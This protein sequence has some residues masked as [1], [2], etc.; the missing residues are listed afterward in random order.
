MKRVLLLLSFI[1]LIT[2]G[3]AQVLPKPS[4]ARLVNDAAHLLTPDQIASLESK[5]V[6]YDDSTSNQVVIVT[7]TTLGDMDANQYATELGRAWGVGGKE[8]N[9]GVVILVSA[10]APETGEQRKVYITAGY[11]LEGAL[12]D[13]TLK[14][15]VDNEMIPNLKL[16]NYYRAF[17]EATTAIIQAAAGE[18]KAPEGYNRRGKQSPIP[19]GVIILIIILVIFFIS[20]SG[21]GGGGMMS[22]RGYR[23]WGAGPVIF[24]G[25]WG[26]G[27][28][29]WSSGGS[30]GGG[31]GFGGFGGGSFGGGGAGGSW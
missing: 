13:I 28:G 22:R 5:L 25:N 15:I 19:V 2:S 26:G 23:R 17:D 6:T 11:G 16:G 12:P 14:E 3:Y 30:S 20:R 31:G 4:P 18:Y 7:V 24:P 10:P 9:N 1:L 8:F 27:G 29:G 21:G